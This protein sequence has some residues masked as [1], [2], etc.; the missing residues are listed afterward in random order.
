MRDFSKII[1]GKFVVLIVL[2]FGAISCEVDDYGKTSIPSVSFQSESISVNTDLGYYDVVVTLSEPARQELVVKLQLSGNAIENEHY[3]I[4]EK[5][6]VIAKGQTSGEVRITILNENIWDENL[7]LKINLAPSVD[8]VIIPEMISATT[9]KFTKEIILPIISFD[10]T[11]TPE[12][13]N[14]FYGEEITFK[15]NID[16]P[17]TAD[18][19]V[20]LD[21]ESEMILGKD[22]LVNDGTSNKLIIPKDATSHTFNIKINKKD[23]AGFDKD[24]KITL[25]P[26]DPK[27]IAVSNETGAF[28]LKV[29]D[30]IVDIS[31]I[32][33]KEAISGNLGFQIYQSIKGTDGSWVGRIVVNSSKNNEKKNYLKTHRNQIFISAFDCMSNTAGGDALCLSNMLNFATNDTVIADYGA[34]STI[35]YFS[36][37]DSLIRFVASK[38]TT[39]KGTLATVNQN[40]SANIILK[41]DWETGVNGQKPWHLDSKAT[42][43]DITKS[44]YPTLATVVIEL[45]KI[46]GTYDFTLEEPELIF[47]AWYKSS[48]PYF[49]KNMPETLAIEKDGDMYKIGYRL[50]PRK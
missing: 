45:V 10:V 29:V 27:F 3:T 6:V 19:E 47:T 42:G 23:D 33:L 4:P 44:T 50:Y 20:V 22:F 36:P 16:Q 49:M 28:T 2:L 46:E 25:I 31:P 12:S 15:L 11:D 17:L 35:R 30:P 37:S 26:T 24:L 8:Y 39:L 21:I 34:S 5:Q 1:L 41:P 13:T 40:F 7:E 32:L 38:E 18:R 9:I 43:G 48:S 14:P